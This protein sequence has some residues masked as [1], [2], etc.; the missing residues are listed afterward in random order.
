MYSFSVEYMEHISDPFG[1]LYQHHTATEIDI[2][3]DNPK[4]MARFITSL[5]EEI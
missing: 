1:Q 3:R 2:R 4:C 5:R